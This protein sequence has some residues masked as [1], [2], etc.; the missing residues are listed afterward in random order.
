MLQ[1][2]ND[3]GIKFNVRII[4]K[5]DSYGL[6]NCLIHDEDKPL[7]EFYDDRYKQG[8]SESGQFVTRYYAETILRHSS[9]CGVDLEGSIADWFISAENVKQVQ[10]YIISKCENFV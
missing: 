3:N 1:V 9:F 6:N 4:R 2:T 8:F 10:R 7:V 5:G